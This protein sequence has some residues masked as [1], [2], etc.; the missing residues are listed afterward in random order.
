MKVVG[1]EMAET[2]QQGWYRGKS[3][4]LRAGYIFNRYKHCDPVPGLLDGL[5][6]RCWIDYQNSKKRH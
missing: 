6:G 5:E 4:P 3:R 2:G 1:E